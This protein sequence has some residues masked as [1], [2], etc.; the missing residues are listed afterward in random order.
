MRQSILIA[1]L[2]LFAVAC[3]TNP[4][5]RAEVADP[6]G[7]LTGLLEEL[8]DARQKGEGAARVEWEIRRLAVFCPR[9]VPTKMA[10]ALIAYRNTDRSLSQQYLDGIFDIQPSHPEA[11]I[12]RTKI[13]IEEGNLP[14]ARKLLAQQMK[15]RPDH[16]GLHESQAGILYLLA[17]FEA[18]RETIDRAARLGAPEWRVAYH[19]GLIEE[20]TENPAAAS[21]YYN[22]CL[23]LNPDW[24]PARSRLIGIEGRRRPDDR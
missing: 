6:D 3:T 12:L 13:A 4:W 5:D 14:Y 10:N 11:A 22:D 18:A 17:E 23:D 7:E 8:E 24:E 15:F 1:A 9:H 21:R 19:L 2:M 20:A 16:A